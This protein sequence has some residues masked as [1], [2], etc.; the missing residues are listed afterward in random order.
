MLNPS[1]MAHSCKDLLDSHLYNTPITKGQ[2]TNPFRNTR[3]ASKR[4][5]EIVSLWASGPVKGTPLNHTPGH[6]YRPKRGRI[7][8][9]IKKRSHVD[10]MT[11]YVN[12][13][14]ASKA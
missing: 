7:T 2:K 14:V 12:V 8:T 13:K 11:S 9:N 3:Y 5:Y 10:N 4:G 1:R 6:K